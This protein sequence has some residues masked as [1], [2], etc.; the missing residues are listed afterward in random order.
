MDSSFSYLIPVLL[1]LGVLVMVALVF[2]L[3]S[4]VKRSDQSTVGEV[5]SGSSDLNRNPYQ[6]PLTLELDDQSLGADP[7]HSNG[8]AALPAVCVVAA[9]AVGGLSHL[10]RQFASLAGIHWEALAALFIL[11][12]LALFLVYLNHRAE[13]KLTH[14]FFQ[15]ENFSLWLAF[16]FGW[17]VLNRG[18]WD[19]F[20]LFNVVA[21]GCS[22]VVG[23]GLLVVLGRLRHNSSPI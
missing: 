10:C 12:G 5:C 20:I 22:A 2:V 3:Q 15:L 13:G 18:L 19:D 17:T 14:L 9:L 16:A 7:R 6:P 11:I 21:M 4:Y 8:R 1:G 23:S